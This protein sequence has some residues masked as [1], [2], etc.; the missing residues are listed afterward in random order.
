MNV[1]VTPTEGD[2]ALACVSVL[3]EELVSCGLADACV[4]PGSR[5]T[6]LALALRR[7]RDVRV[8]VHLDERASAFFALGL[9]KA[10]GR[11]VALACTSGTAV[12]EYLPAIVEASL[13][14]VP[15]LVLTAD[16]PA[17]LRNVG[18]N[19]TIDQPGIY[20][21]YVRSSVEAEVPGDRPEGAYWRGLATD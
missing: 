11:P 3:V 5:S 8:H 17:E 16:R 2:V 15:L 4:S 13:T 18:A 19:Q 6:P 1:G 10:S 21:R 14:R 7:N 20:G 12:A 9:A